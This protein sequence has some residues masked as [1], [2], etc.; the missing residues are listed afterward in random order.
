VSAPARPLQ[1][2]L[3]L[4]TFNAIRSPIAEGIARKLL[5]RHVYVE[6]AGLKSTERN[7]FALAVLRE[8]GIDFKEDE[9]H[10]IEALAMDG[11]DLVVTLSDEARD[12]AVD[13]LGLTSV[14]HLHWPIADPS[15]VGGARD[16]KLD[17][18][19]A[20]RDDLRQ[21]IR[22]ELLPRVRAVM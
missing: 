16:A 1:S 19:R 4:C 9:P 20:V 3:F 13:R 17:A 10:A 22:L 18:Y 12:L 2:I 21:R 11:F 14:E 8:I 7:Q 15:L 5:G 6:S